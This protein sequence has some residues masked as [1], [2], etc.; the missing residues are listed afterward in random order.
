ML[1]TYF[2]LFGSAVSFGLAVSLVSAV[3]FGPA[4]SFG[5]AVS[6]GSAVLFASA[7]ATFVEL[8]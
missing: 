7:V 2:P 4:V 8:Q 6:C 1:H 3:L 5:S